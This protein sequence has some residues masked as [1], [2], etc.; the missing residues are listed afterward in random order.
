MCLPTLSRVDV[1]RSILGADSVVGW[2][3]RHWVL[4]AFLWGARAGLAGRV[5]PVI[6]H[7]GGHHQCE[8][9]PGTVLTLALGQ[10]I[11][12]MIIHW[13]CKQKQTT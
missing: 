8:K 12:L 4:V 11:V 10:F 5:R 3:V 9:H 6:T 13:L 2:V 1:P 7:R